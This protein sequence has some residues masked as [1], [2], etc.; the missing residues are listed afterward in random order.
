[1]AEKHYWLSK[2]KSFGRKITFGMELPE[3]VDSDR[4]KLLKSQGLISNKKPVTFS[5]AQ[6]SALEVATSE[7]AKLKAELSELK[8]KEKQGGK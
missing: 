3:T 8:K 5:E 7:N 1:M 6:N 2:Q 4:I